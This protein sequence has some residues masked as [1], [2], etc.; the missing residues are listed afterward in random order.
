L[1]GECGDVWRLRRSIGDETYE[2]GIAQIMAESQ[3]LMSERESIVKDRLAGNEK[4][5]DF[6]DN[7]GFSVTMP[8][9]QLNLC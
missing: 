8:G 3:G 7:I 4:A 2:V 5:T 6:T 1:E 9:G